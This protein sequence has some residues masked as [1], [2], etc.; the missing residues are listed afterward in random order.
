MPLVSSSPMSGRGFCSDG[1]FHS[2][3]TSAFCR[4][5]SDFSIWSG[6]IFTVRSG[7]TP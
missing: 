3:I 7:L 5:V 2:S 4:S 6:D 1:S